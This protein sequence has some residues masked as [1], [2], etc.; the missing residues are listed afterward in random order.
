MS[1]GKNKQHERASEALAFFGLCG[2]ISVWIIYLIAY[3][4]EL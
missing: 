1:Q 4:F 2:I 3:L